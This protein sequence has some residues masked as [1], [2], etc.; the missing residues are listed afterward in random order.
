MSEL[1]SITVGALL[2]KVAK[3]YPDDQA[4]KYTDRPFNMTWRQ[5]CIRDRAGDGSSPALPI[6]ASLAR[7]RRITDARV[8]F[9]RY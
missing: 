9:V 6:P 7:M 3:M 2:E 4:V 1:I 8:P 5:M